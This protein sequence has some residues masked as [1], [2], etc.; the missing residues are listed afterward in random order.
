MKRLF[1]FISLVCGVACSSP[2]VA[3]EEL[4]INASFEEQGESADFAKGW[5][6]WGNWI[7]RETGWNP[8]LDGKCLLGYHHWQIEKNETSGFY[9][10][11][12]NVEPGRMCTFSIYVNTDAVAEGQQGPVSVEIRLETTVYDEQSVVISQHYE[13]SDLAGGK[14]WSR[15][16]VRAKTPNRRLRALVLITPAK[17]NGSRGGALK[18]DKASVVLE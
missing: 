18:F 2:A 15:L 8:V 3:G 16:S 13:V 1:V 6:R 5:S 11:L 14:D 10:D 12:E 9:Q 7:N 17:G 4:L